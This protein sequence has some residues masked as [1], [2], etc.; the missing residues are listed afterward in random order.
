MVEV[1]LKNKLMPIIDQAM[2]EKAVELLKYVSDNYTTVCEDE[3][4]HD[5][6]LN[7]KAIS[8][9]EVYDLFIKPKSK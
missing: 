4:I 3:F 5:K 9:I 6:D 7:S 8:S 1:E 2:R